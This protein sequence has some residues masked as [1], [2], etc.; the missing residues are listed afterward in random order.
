LKA[1]FRFMRNAVILLLLTMNH[2]LIVTYFIPENPLTNVF[3]ILLAITNIAYL[4]RHFTLTIRLHPL[5][6]A[7]DEFRGHPILYVNLFLGVL[8]NAAL[9]YLLFVHLI[10]R[11]FALGGFLAQ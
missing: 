3:M 8:V 11:I 2:L 10:A 1:P 9:M 4:I 6:K 5:F 7:D